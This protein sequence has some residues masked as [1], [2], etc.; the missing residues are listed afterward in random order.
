[1]DTNNSLMN[2]YFM[3]YEMGDIDLIKEFLHE[4]H[5]YYPPAGGD[6]EDLEQRMNE[7]KFFLLHSLKLK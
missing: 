4:K 3:T 1:M 6:P 2:K 7:E 5:I